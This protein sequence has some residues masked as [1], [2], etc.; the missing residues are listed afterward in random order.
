MIPKPCDDYPAKVIPL[1]TRNEL[2]GASTDPGTGFDLCPPSLAVA[3]ARSVGDLRGPGCVSKEG[4]PHFFTTGDPVVCRVA[5]FR[6]LSR[7]RTYPDELD[8]PN[9]GHLATGDA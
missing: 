9:V 1:R 8:S 5:S 3:S 7:R 4:R 2:G 6:S